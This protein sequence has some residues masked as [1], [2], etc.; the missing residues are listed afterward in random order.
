M[1]HE[2]DPAST[3]GQSASPSLAD[4]LLPYQRR[5]EEELVKR[6]EAAQ[7][8]F[9]IDDDA[10]PVR[11]HGAQQE[12][13]SVIDPIRH[14]IAAGGK[15]LR[16]VLCLLAAEAISGESEHAVAVATGI[17]YL[18]TFTLVHD[19]VMDEDLMRRGRPTVHA[20]WGAPMAITAGDGLYALAM[21]TL[22]DDEAGGDA[23]TLAAIARQAA[24]VSFALCAGQTRDLLFE[25][26]DS[27]TLDEYHKMIE[28]KTAVLMG[29]SME[30]GARIS[31]AEKDDRDD[32]HE[33]GMRLGLAFQVTDDLLDLQAS[34][35]EIGKPPDSDLRAGKKTYPIVHALDNL[36]PGKRDRL[37]KLLSA[38][39]KRTTPDMVQEMRSLLDEAGSLEASS[40]HAKLLGTQA[41]DA[42][43]RFQR[44]RGEDNKTIQILKE[45]VDHVVQRRH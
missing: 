2:D 29:L 43:A 44:R 9:S 21:A 5:I 28:E 25:S 14:V 40:E 17:E 20:I 22:L 4:R 42:L 38:P 34:E 6:L 8:P 10:P 3:V 35:Q 30:T 7:L 33:Y 15:R 32:L 36:E 37:Q 1:A 12:L 11:P 19:D 16:P 23:A 39:E 13:A 18:H 31:G 26:R 41:K 27:V 45:L 24:R